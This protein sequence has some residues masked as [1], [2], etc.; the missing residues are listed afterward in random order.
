[1]A[2][3]GFYA[4]DDSGRN[5]QRGYG[6]QRYGQNQYEEQESDRTQYESSTYNSQR[7]GNQD[8]QEGYGTG[9]RDR[10]GQQEEDSPGYGEGRRNKPGR[11]QEDSYENQYS[12]GSQYGQSR[13]D[14][15]RPQQGREQYG[16]QQPQQ[17]SYGD[18]SEER[19]QYDNGQSYGGNKQHKRD[20]QEGRISKNPVR[21]E[22]GLYFGYGSGSEPPS[23]TGDRSL[24]SDE[25][26]GV[27]T[28]STASGSSAGYGAG[29]PQR[30]NPA[31][32]EN[33]SRGASQQS[34][35][36]QE[37]HGNFSG[38]SRDI[39]LRGSILSARCTDVRGN[40]TQS[41]IDLNDLFTNEWGSLKWKRGG[42]FA[43]SARNLRLTSNGKVLE[44]ELG[45]G[46][47]GWQRN[48]VYL[49]ERIGND[50]GSLSFVD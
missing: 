46:Q 50:N 49:D 23:Q 8:R 1:M 10:Y 40:A 13:N 31:Q 33:S 5:T 7:Y 3:R 11:R 2:A 48:T 39:S 32:R 35:P 21:L 34:R 44:C 17:S 38:S 25:S 4:G 43:G 9:Q 16:R 19:N 12:Q 18:A 27:A 22:N 26:Y 14:Y 45:D 36:P 41:E 6:S 15:D 37:M 28:S 30:E 29:R 42:N 20:N 24:P 47:G